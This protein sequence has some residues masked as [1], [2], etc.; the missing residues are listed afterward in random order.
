MA[1][2][3]LDYYGGKD[4]YSDGSVED[5]ILNIVKTGQEYTNYAGC[6][7][8]YPIMYHLSPE[9][10]NVLNWY[11]F[12]KSDTIL[13][14]GSGCGAITGLLCKR[15]K[16]VTSVEL[17]EKRA[18]VNFERH[19]ACDNLEIMV[20]NL[21]DMHLDK[22]YDYVVLTGVF[23]YAMSFTDS[24]EPYVTFLNNFKKYL[25]EKGRILISIENR[26]GVKYFSGAMEDHTDE[27]Y[28]GLNNY[29]ENNTVR[30]FSKAELEKIFEAC[31]M[32]QWKF[33]YPY[34]DYKFPTEIFTDKNINA[35][36]YGRVYRNYQK[37]R[38]E[39]FNELE[40]IR[41]FKQ[42]KVMGSFANSFLVEVAVKDVVL[43]NVVYAK[44][45]NS[46]RNRFCIATVILND[47]QGG[48]VEK[49][50]LSDEAGGH[51]RSVY[52]N[53]DKPLPEGFKYLKG[54]L[55]EDAI[56]YPLLQ[57]ENL[58]SYMLRQIETG[59]VAAV[60]EKIDGIYN[61]LAEKADT[62][63]QIYCE[64][65]RECF[66]DARFSGVLQCIK[67]CDIDLIFDNLYPDG[68]G[69]MVIDPEWVCPFWVPVQ[70]IAWRMLNEWYSKYPW[71]DTVLPSREMYSRYNIS[72]EMEN[73]FRQWAIH[74]ATRYV[75]ISDLD[76]AAVQ[77]RKL[78]VNHLVQKEIQTNA[79]C[80]SFYI[81]Y[82]QGFSESEKIYASAALEK[83]SFRIH[84][85]LD[86]SKRIRAI[87]W[88]PVEY[89]F[90]RCSVQSCRLD[91]RD[92]KI[93]PNNPDR[94]DA[95]LFWDMDP[96]FTLEIMPGNYGELEIC[97]VFEY[98]QDD[99]IKKKIDIEVQQAAILSA[100]NEVLR[101]ECEGTKR[102]LAITQDKLQETRDELQEAQ[103]KLGF[104]ESDLQ[105]I[106]NSKGWRVLNV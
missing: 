14:I 75:S 63:E 28:L 59:K 92:I 100:E 32:H 83:G 87:R 85:G 11:P 17:S 89:R 22:K 1:I 46:R 48:R 61:R 97:G 37:G 24:E 31:G 99:F 36:H 80:S 41:T 58:D 64:Q 20:G 79:M 25:N 84:V 47:G 62:M 15:S 96:Q 65:F 30:T 34:P 10:E 104:A 6:D 38:V 29:A 78:S 13:E 88:D 67:E 86:N 74:F 69:Y 93:V 26:L 91:K 16:W 77:I 23:E 9:R 98:L 2:F 33:Y 3:N 50:A 68:E 19:K 4:L 40:M 53:Q 102:N 81:D 101:D 54:N 57:D 105:A 44:L 43:S 71:I 90:C 82:G 52:A 55:R 51:I 60:Q 73:V 45:N 35:D 42:E 18:Q 21:N 76:G 8:Y 94:S 66:G 70:F 7:N 103:S 39:L 5:V 72:K 12:Q 49:R 106:R 56:V 27:Y 95:A